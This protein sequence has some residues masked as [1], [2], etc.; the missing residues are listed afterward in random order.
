MGF[1]NLLKNGYRGKLGETVGQKWKN[2]LTVRTYQS[3][4]NSKSKEQLDQRAHYKA[5]IQE[6]S[7][8]YPSTYNLI[9]PKKKS[10]NKFNFFTSSL[11][12]IFENLGKNNFQFPLGDYRAKNVLCPWGGIKNNAMYAYIILPYGQPPQ[13]IL[14]IPQSIILGMDGTGNP[15]SMPDGILE[16]EIIPKRVK[17][18]AT[19][20]PFPRGYFV[21]T[22]INPNARDLFF[23]AVGRRERGATKWSEVTMIQPVFQIT[24]DQLEDL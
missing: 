15:I 14:S 12:S 18:G 24:D 22:K 17:A 3:T 9:V 8:F 6:S 1:I 16:Q 13:S 19:P 20:Y 11:E 21:K 10:M 2:Q 4:N 5:L 7:R 23:F